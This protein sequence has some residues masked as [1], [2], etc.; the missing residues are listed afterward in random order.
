MRSKAW[1]QRVRHVRHVRFLGVVESAVERM[2]K[3]LFAHTVPMAQPIGKLRPQRRTANSPRTTIDPT[4]H[5]GERVARKCTASEAQCMQR[6]S[7]NELRNMRGR[8]GAP[9]RLLP[10]VTIVSAKEASETFQLFEPH[11]NTA[12]PHVQRSRVPRSR[13]LTAGRVASLRLYVVFRVLFVVV[14]M[15]V[16][17]RARCVRAG[18]HVA[19]CVCALSRVSCMLRVRCHACRTC[20]A[21]FHHVA[22]NAPMTYR[23]KK[24]NTPLNTPETPKTYHSTQQNTENPHPTP[25]KNTSNATEKQ[26]MPLNSAE[27]TT[28]NE[29]HQKQTT[30]LP[31]PQTRRNR[32][33]PEPTKNRKHT[34]KKPQHTTANRKQT[35]PYWHVGFSSML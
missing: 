18:L 21:R 29:T 20:R 2:K 9:Q 22:D 28:K 30:T 13:Q 1:Q 34:A 27:D 3:P 10:H 16:V 15:R 14:I 12:L 8:T 24:E 33:S 6:G 11:L 31:Q 35:T 4:H 25:Q 5:G 26:N 32:T 17:C 19:L 23:K 7:N